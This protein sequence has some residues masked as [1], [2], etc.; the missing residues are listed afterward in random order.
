MRLRDAAYAPVLAL[1]MGLMLARL[2]VMARLLPIERFSAY[3]LGIL[4]SSSFC[5]L[6]CLG[7]QSLLQRELPVQILRGRERAGGILTMQCVA[8]AIACAG[9]SGLLAGLWALND[10]VDTQV[11]LPGL[12][13]GLSQQVF[14]IATVESRS[15]GATMR[16]ALDNL[17]RAVGVTLAGALI[18]L[19][20]FGARGA[21]SAEA[22]VSLGLAA[23]LCRNQLR[24]ARMSC[25]AAVVLALK[26]LPAA[27]WQ[28]AVSLLAVMALSFVI[29]NVDRWVGAWVLDTDGFAQYAFAWI[30][31]MV[32]QSTQVVINASLYPRLAQRFALAGAPAA[33]ALARRASLSLLVF[34]AALAVPAWFAFRIVVECCFSTYGAAVSVLPLFLLVGVLRI[35]EFWSSYLIVGGHERQLFLVNLTLLACGGLLWWLWFAQDARSDLLD[36]AVL[37]ALLATVGY[38]TIAVAAWRLSRL[39]GA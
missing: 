5:M 17:G 23:L 29:V 4:I 27:P 24:T 16:F 26:R 3:S 38:A 19:L 21:L 2:L 15:R 30:V 12:L 34:G 39:R 25:T 10:G 33:F 7:F 8:I 20:G 18:V 36:V 9:L 13:H 31:L 11:V 6:G 28:T 32:A 35:S 37:P 22:V 1:A 14:L